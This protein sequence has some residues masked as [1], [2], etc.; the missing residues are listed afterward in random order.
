MDWSL[1]LL[2]LLTLPSGIYI[3]GKMLRC[4]I[5]DFLIRKHGTSCMGIIDEIPQTPTGKNA[6]GAH[7]LIRVNGIDGKLESVRVLSW[8]SGQQS[9]CGKPIELVFSE[10]Y[11]GR[12]TH[13]KWFSLWLEALIFLPIGIF[14]ILVGL[15]SLGRM[16]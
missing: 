14:F 5:W 11:P 16:L 10:R 8:F 9:N 7:P 12:C 15:E 6:S 4:C 1:I 3:A 13:G 2:A